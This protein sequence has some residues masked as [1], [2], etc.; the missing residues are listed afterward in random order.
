[1]RERHGLHKLVTYL[2]RRASQ[3]LECIKSRLP[4]SL[5]DAKTELS[6][7]P[8][9]FLPTTTTAPPWTALSDSTSVVRGLFFFEWHL[10]PPAWRAPAYSGSKMSPV[11]P[12]ETRD[13][14]P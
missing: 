9:K 4:Q 14:P 11:Y 13:R 7:A 6:S 3:Q 1:M 10:P 12:A 2:G 5:M 8:T